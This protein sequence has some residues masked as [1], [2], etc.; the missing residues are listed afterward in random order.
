MVL[1]PSPFGRRITDLTPILIRSELGVLC[2]SVV[3]FPSVLC[4]CHLPVWMNPASTDA[5]IS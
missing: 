5:S 3:K 2:A 4:P 1:P